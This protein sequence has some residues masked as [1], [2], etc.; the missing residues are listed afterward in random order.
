MPRGET[1]FNILAPAVVQTHLSFGAS[2]KTGGGEWS[3]FYTQAFRHTV[4][5][6]GSIPPAF[7]GGE[8]DVQLREHIVGL[9]YSWA[10]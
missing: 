4:K 1:F 3:A 7:G 8:A 6:Q 5:G 10:W 2:L 9:A